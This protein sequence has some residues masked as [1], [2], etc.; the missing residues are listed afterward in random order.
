MTKFRIRYPNGR[1]IGPFSKEQLFELKAKGHIKGSEE[2]QVFPDGDWAGF[3]A[4]SVYSEVMEDT[5]PP[6]PEEKAETFVID[7]TKLRQQLQEKEIENLSPQ[8]IVPVELTETVR[9][10]FDHSGQ[11]APPSMP[12]DPQSLVMELPHTSGGRRPKSQEPEESNSDKTMLN[13]LAQKEIARMKKLEVQA[14]GI[15]ESEEKKKLELQVYQEKKAQEEALLP[16]ILPEDEATQRIRIQHLDKNITEAKEAERDLELELRGIR[17]KERELKRALE[18]PD[19]EEEDEIEDDPAKKKR[20]KIIIAVSLLVL[21]YV[22][23]YPSDKGLNKPPYVYLPPQI[24]FPIPFD[25]ADMNKSQ[26]ELTQGQELHA[27]GTYPSIVKAG[28]KFKSS[29]ENNLENL[30]ALNLLVR[31]YAEE[32]EYSKNKLADAQ[33]LFNI[34]QSKRP[35]L[36]QDPNGV[37]GLNLF[38]MSLG[39]TDAAVD[40]VSKFLKLQP[41]KVTQDLFSI[42]LKSLLEAG[43]VDLAKQFYTAL[44]KAPEKNR[45]TLSALIDYL[46]LNQETEKA[47][48]YLDQAIKTNPKVVKFQLLKA[49]QLISEKKFKEAI[50]LLKAVEAQNYEYNDVSR[51][52]FLELTGLLLAFKGD[53]KAATKMLSE[54]LSINESTKL[55][56][57]LAELKSSSTSPEDTAKLIAESKSVQLLQ[58]AKDFFDKRNYELA[59]SYAA[60]ASDSYP[61]HIPSEIFLSRTQLKLGHAKHGLVTLENLH[62]KYPDDRTIN[63]ALVDAYVQTYKVQDAKNRIAAIA[64]TELKGSWEFASYNAKLSLKMGDTLQAMSWLKVSTSLNP[65]NDQDIF[66]LAEIL[67]KKSN[68]EAVRTLLNRCM[69]LDPANPDYRI[70]YAKM[71]YETQDDQAAV[72]YLL[73]L[74]EEF[75]ENPKFLSEIAIFYFR[76]GKVKDF[77]D[78]KAKI[79]AL[80][81]KDKTLYEFLIRAALMDER[82]EEIPGLVEQLLVIE[83]GDIESMMTAGRVLFESG[84]LVDAAK[85]FKR[86]QEKL[87]TY[88]KV[89]YYIARIKFLSRD[90]DGAMAEIKKNIKVNGENDADLILMA[91]IHVEKEDYVEAENLFKRAQKMNPRSYDALVGLADLSTKRNNFDLALDLYKRALK[92]KTDEPVVHRKVGDVYRLLGQGT[93]AIE[94]YKMYLE[95]DPEATDRGKIESYI[96]LMQ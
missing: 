82:F 52:K 48:G 36:I 92:Q 17:K 24:I 44:E 37:I 4:L 71:V 69:E 42:Y 3:S 87:D 29:Y 56:M 60:K 63:F 30:L 10:P 66:S 1:V 49:E 43:K 67:L 74:L 70:A 96:K 22:I 94:S 75:G 83:P 19:Q 21:C 7:L 27:K 85:W 58:Q 11:Q 45:Y 80:P 8:T 32:L 72:G 34:I 14:R 79:E 13:P 25:Q 90:F 81:N 95:M 59:L 88:P 65:L 39:K 15:K 16:V 57:K 64:L 62:R 35:L 50:P 20:L 46:L 76:A 93:L 55:R 5:T 77:Q 51:S 68:F 54:S 78:Y 6:V 61:G 91:Q 31:T 38:Y 23:L 26:V 28:L 2:A 18:E 41:K 47:R 9:V 33:I 84:K 40:V 86:I 12:V 53:V 73:G 89:L